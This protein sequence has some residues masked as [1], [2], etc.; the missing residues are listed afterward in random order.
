MTTCPKCH[1][2]HD[3]D[4]CQGH[5]IRDS[6]TRE[7]IAPR[8]CAKQPMKAQHVCRSHGG[9][10]AKSRAAAE[11]RQAETA[12]EQS[13]T[14]LWPGLSPDRRVTDPL[15]SLEQL[16]GAVEYMVDV[17]GNRLNEAMRVVARSWP[18]R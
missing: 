13:L 9:A 16:A 8:Q 10:T 15:G 5:V 1:T 2:T 18:A 6:T 4:L 12:A 17:V 11:N 3:P 14:K 7:P